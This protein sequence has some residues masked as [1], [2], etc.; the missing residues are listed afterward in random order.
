MAVGA[1]YRSYF[2][3]RLPVTANAEDGLDDAHRAAR[4]DRGRS[5]TAAALYLKRGENEEAKRALR[6]VAYDPHG[7][8]MS[9]AA[10]RILATL[11]KGDI[12]AARAALEP[13]PQADDAN[14]D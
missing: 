9:I 2:E 8:D 13:A 5:L 1:F 10:G 7:G 11:D 12:A 14:N 3:A 4:Y 6:S